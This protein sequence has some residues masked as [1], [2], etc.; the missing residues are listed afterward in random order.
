ML[1]TE[2][3]G[4]QGIR[5]ASDDKKGTVME[6]LA[7]K[8]AVITGGASGM[9]ASHARLFAAEGANVVITDID[10]DSGAALADELGANALFVKHDVSD[11][12][13]WADVVVAANDRFGPI[14]VLVNN[15]GVTGPITQIAEL[16][17]HDYL[18]TVNIDLNGSFYGTRAVVPEMTAAGGG[19]IV[20]ISSVAGFS[21]L[22]GTP[23]AAYT[24]AKFGVRGLTKATAAEYGSRNIR[25]N[26]VHPGPVATPLFLETLPEET[27]AAIVAAVPLGRLAGPEEVSQLILFL[28]S[29]DASYITGGEYVIDGGMLAQ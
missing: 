18:R 16:S 17:D 6:R 8:V 22:P 25:V 7:G 27:I 15:A 13:S 5:P 23:N 9:G 10:E 28:V 29:D 1:F 19:A 21:H 14:T 12:A 3:Q 11:P 4:A 26:S 20:N 24:T 2:R